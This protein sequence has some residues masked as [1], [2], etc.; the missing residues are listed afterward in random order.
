MLKKF[1]RRIRK[2]D[3]FDEILEGVSFGFSTIF[4]ILLSHLISALL[5]AIFEN[6][7]NIIFVVMLI[8]T[9]LSFVYLQFIE[10]YKSKIKVIYDE[11]LGLKSIG[12]NSNSDYENLFKGFGMENTTVINDIKVLLTIKIEDGA[13]FYYNHSGIMELY[14]PCTIEIFSE[15]GEVYKKE[16]YI[17]ITKDIVK[18]KSLLIT[19]VI[20]ENIDSIKESIE[21]K[22]SSLNKLK[23]VENIMKG[24]N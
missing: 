15:Y 8:V 19:Q 5:G 17:D 14:Q 13:D 2:Y 9:F 4:S 3:L 16:C 23:E 1:I 11:L 22:K 7:I 24:V 10:T 6:Y 20:K 12:L 21:N 18:D